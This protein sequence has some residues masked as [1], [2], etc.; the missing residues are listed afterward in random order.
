MRANRGM[1]FSTNRKK[2]VLP[3]PATADTSNSGPAPSF[4]K[5]WVLRLRDLNFSKSGVFGF[6]KTDHFNAC[7]NFRASR[8]RA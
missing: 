2:R 8:N 5:D 6:A 7:S 4:R 1:T 3:T